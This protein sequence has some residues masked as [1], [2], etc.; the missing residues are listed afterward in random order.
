MA[1]DPELA[2]TI[3]LTLNDMQRAVFNECITGNKS[4]FCTGQGGTGKSWLI[5]A[6]IKYFR[7]RNVKDKSY[8]SVTASTGI[9]AYLIRGI[10]LHRFAGVG[11]EEMDLTAMIRKASSGVS[12]DFWIKTSILIIDEISMVSPYL[13]NNLSH[14]GQAIRK[15]SLP[16]GG[17]KVLMFGD[18][19]QLPPIIKDGNQ[20][21]RVFNTDAWRELNPSIYELTTIMRQRD[22]VFRQ[23]LSELR[24]GQCSLE[25]EDYIKSLSR[26]L[27]YD[28]DVEPVRLFA[29]R[30]STDAYNSTRLNQLQTPS[31][32]YHSIDKGDKSSLK[33]CPA[34]ES[35]VLKEG[36]QI[37]LTR[38]LS[39]RA[40]N[41]SLGT[42]TGFEYAKEV[43]SYQPVV[44][45]VMKGASS[46]T[47][48]ISTVVWESVSPT[49]S[50]IASRTQVP[51]ILA[52]AITIHKS[53]GQTIPRLCVDMTGIFETGQAYVALSR[54]PDSDNL[55]VINFK[56]HLI[57]AAPG[58]VDFHESVSSGRYKSNATQ[59]AKDTPSSWD[60]T[61]V[62]TS[63]IESLTMDTQ[64]MLGRLSLQAPSTTSLSDSEH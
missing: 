17:I 63:P 24:I 4:I 15:S 1:S 50:V 60:S 7:D 36:C 26:P 62:S 57:M 39:P 48:I 41:G 25:S 14:V 55:Q 32:S 33:Q 18:F 49:G 5:Q 27:E 51:L 3:G 53:Q 61:T 40:V 29:L 12:K 2:K 21:L 9:A 30:K 23:V 19:L 6:I 46:F 45:F 47:M 42:V 64:F 59:V 31:R 54:C 28:D 37:I 35:V 56:R 8:I 22:K 38:N 10:T 52:W 44:K 11:I 43:K 58:S 13:F 34:P 20:S 16:F